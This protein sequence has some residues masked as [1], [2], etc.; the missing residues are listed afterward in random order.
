MGTTRGRKRGWRFPIC[1]R[2]CAARPN[3][4]V[5]GQ[6]EAEYAWCAISDSLPGLSVSAEN[7]AY[8]IISACRHGDPELTISLPAKLAIVANHL[9][10][11]AIARAMIVANRFLP[12]PN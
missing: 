1:C 5:R 3:A 8:Q 11:S 12:G 2:G 10:P 9:T 4:D 6:H 7:A